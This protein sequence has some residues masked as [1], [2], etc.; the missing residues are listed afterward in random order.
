MPSIS[1]V[2]KQEI[3]FGPK[4]L[5]ISFQLS[6]QFRDGESCNIPIS[7]SGLLV[8]PLRTR[9][10]PLCSWGDN[11]S[12]VVVAWL[13]VSRGNKIWKFSIRL[14]I[15][16]FNPDFPFPLPHFSRR[17]K[18]T[19]EGVEDLYYARGWQRSSGGR[20]GEAQKGCRASKEGKRT[21]RE[22]WKEVK[23]GGGVCVWRVWRPLRTVLGVVAKQRL[24][25]PHTH[26]MSPSHFSSNPQNSLAFSLYTVY[27]YGTIY[28]YTYI[29]VLRFLRSCTLMLGYTVL[30]QSVR[31]F[32]Y[33]LYVFHLSLSCSFTFLSYTYLR[34]L[35][36][37]R[38]SAS[39]ASARSYPRRLPTVTRLWISFTFVL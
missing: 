36:P 39:A 26:T 29:H 21:K 30:L 37:W 23:G 3:A 8:L 2:S 31:L 4:N 9:V 12:K 19:V 14:K 35:K 6:L 1:R 27:T 18:R 16:E 5:S 11:G 28:T 17:G 15:L 32:S 38:A 13:R 24:P 22:G 20:V 34:K 33:A 25:T 7:Y 10:Y